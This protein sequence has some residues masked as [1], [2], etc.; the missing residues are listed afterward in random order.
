[1]KLK[2]DEN[3]PESLV[4]ELAALGHNIDCVRQEGLAGQDDAGIWAAAQREGRFLL[5][6]DLDFSDV[7][8]FQPGTH[9]GLLLVRLPDAGAQTLI[10]QL[11]DVFKRER[12]EDWARC[13]V[14]LSDHKLRVISPPRVD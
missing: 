13:F 10:E 9:H 3:L 12:V 7:R 4:A 8:Q 2:L 14:V 1:M 6:Q 11:V 5:T